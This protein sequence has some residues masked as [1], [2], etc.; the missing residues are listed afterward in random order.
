[1]P[2]YIIGWL[3]DY[4][5]PHNW[6][7]PYMHS[8]GTFSYF[9]AYADPAVDAMV[10]AGVTETDDNKRIEIYWKLGNIMFEDAVSFA[11]VQATGRHWERDWM[12][13]WY[14]NPIYP[15]TYW[16]HLW[17]GYAADVNFDYVVNLFDLTI[18]G[19][20]WDATPASGNWA[21]CADIDNDGHVFLYDLTIVG[22]Y[23]D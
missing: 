14:N 1:M 11:L 7:Y 2:F 4:P 13:G 9:Q 22:T 3:A 21:A 15:G 19:S 18:I 20:A 17:K 12:Q 16:Y 5:D 6:Y 10:E 23:Y 8:H